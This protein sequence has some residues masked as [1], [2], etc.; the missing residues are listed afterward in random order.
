MSVNEDSV[1]FS[2]SGKMAKLLGRQS[3]S[4]D[5]VA[6]FEL[7]K[8][9][10]DADSK[11]VE[12]TFNGVK[13]SEGKLPRDTTSIT[14]RDFGNGMTVS[15]FKKSW[16]IIGT[17]SKNSSPY[18]P[19]GRKV[20]GEKGIGRFATERLS[21]R[22]TVESIPEF[23]DTNPDYSGLKSVLTIEWDLYEKEGSTFDQIKHQIK[24]I[25][26]EPADKPGLKIVLE[27]LRED[28]DIKKI[29][30]LQ[31]ELSTLILPETLRENDSFDIDLKVPAF[32]LQ[33]IQVESSL[34]EHAGY[35]LSAE[36][37]DDRIHLTLFYKGKQIIPDQHN[38]YPGT[39]PKTLE[40]NIPFKN[41]K[42]GKV[43]FKMYFFPHDSSGKEEWRNYYGPITSQLVQN[44]LKDNS[45]VRIYRDGF[46]VK[47]YGD[48]GHDWASLERKA[49]GAP[50]R[51]TANRVLAR[52]EITSKD[53]PN[54]I[55][56]TTRE[57]IIEN[58]AFTD[59]KEFVILCI[60]KLNAAIGLI[61]REKRKKEGKKH[62][63]ALLK[64]VKSTI[65]ILDID[66]TQKRNVTRTLSDIENQFQTLTE[67][68]ESEQNLLMNRIDAYRSLA[69]LGITAGVVFHE[70]REDMGTL[71]TYTN[72]LKDNIE[73]ETPDIGTLRSDINVIH[74]VVENIGYYSEFV[75]G[76]LSTLTSKSREFRRR[77]KINLYDMI[78]NRHKGLSGVLSKLN[79]SF[80]NS[81]SPN[82][83][84]LYMMKSD[85]ESILN[86]LIVNS[87]KALKI[88]DVSKTELKKKVI[89]IS[90]DLD[91][92]NCILVVSDNG[93]G[94]H[95]DIVKDIFEE[96]ESYSE[97]YD[98]TKSGAGLGLPIVKEIIE[99]YH[100]KI[101]IIKSELEHGA[102]FK[103]T[104]PLRSITEL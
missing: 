53:N 103:I 7:V 17:E 58:D 12:I 3:V 56:T 50:G 78:E 63:P 33:T 76:H 65:S 35:F 55:D 51:P 72:L 23:E 49:T 41:K 84:E 8:N 18:S 98:A 102:T 11:K 43:K 39:N 31:T 91:K 94:I 80:M 75:M 34:Y 19:G 85:L 13:N 37:L 54:I 9:A 95:P 36:N 69:S 21:R 96:F 44:V 2:F 5:I 20:V 24:L 30:R 79:I 4:S 90:A 59:L 62:I 77:Q 16:L 97:A 87:I 67:E 81:V 101:E 38:L 52:V 14:I 64:R 28:W 86:N 47:P 1:A 71:I 27:K 25:P 88:T 45:G 32:N 99:K 29:T 61:N 10:Y 26:K 66:Q 57:K 104:I 6:L 22:T 100:G 46:R 48:P 15:E 74:P 60:N 93:P 42:C 40:S 73:S 92:T 68:V 82:F 70:T 83:S 89:K